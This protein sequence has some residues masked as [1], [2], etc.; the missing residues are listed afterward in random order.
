MQGIQSRTCLKAIDNPLF[1]VM[2]SKVVISYVP[3]EDIVVSMYNIICYF[4]VH[5]RQLNARCVQRVGIMVH[6]D[7]FKF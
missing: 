4:E 1:L 2:I 6:L 7:G 5:T 3:I